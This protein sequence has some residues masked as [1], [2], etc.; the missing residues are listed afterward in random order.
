MKFMKVFFNPQK[1][2]VKLTRKNTMVVDAIRSVVP[3]S[4]FHWSDVM[5]FHTYV[6]NAWKSFLV[7]DLDQ[8]MWPN[9]W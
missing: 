3:T 9:P 7:A 2:G 5:V 6:E 1:D 4:F 8:R